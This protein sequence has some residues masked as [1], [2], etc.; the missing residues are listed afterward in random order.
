M[1]NKEI[2]GK[3]NHE[4]KNRTNQP[5]TSQME[6]DQPVVNEQEQV[7][8]VNPQDGMFRQD[9]SEDFT[10]EK[11]MNRAQQAD[12]ENSTR[13]QGDD[14][15]AENTESEIEETDDTSTQTPKVN[16]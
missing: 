8:A 1:K 16:P 9:T 10:S 6:K 11:E 15:D 2:S 4:N 12:T 5:S 3:V 13:N 7:Y 14:Y